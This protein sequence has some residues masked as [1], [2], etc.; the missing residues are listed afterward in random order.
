MRVFSKDLGN[1]TIVTMPR[2]T[3]KWSDFALSRYSHMQHLTFQSQ[4]YGENDLE[5][6][7]QELLSSNAQ[8]IN[9]NDLKRNS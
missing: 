6:A 2:G 5:R 7:L 9:D 8:H 1:H 3:L 4:A